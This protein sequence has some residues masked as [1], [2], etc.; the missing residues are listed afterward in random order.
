MSRREIERGVLFIKKSVEGSAVK[1]SQGLVEMVGWIRE[2]C[3]PGIFWRMNQSR[4]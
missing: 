3:I 4:V 1:L 2:P